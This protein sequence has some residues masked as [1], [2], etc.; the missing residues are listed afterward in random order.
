[1]LF[2]PFVVGAATPNTHE[3]LCRMELEITEG[4][5]DTQGALVFLL[6]RCISNRQKAAEAQRKA[7]V[8]AARSENMYPGDKAQVER[9]IRGSADRISRQAIKRNAAGRK[10]E[11]LRKNFMR[12]RARRTP[13]AGTGS[14][15][16]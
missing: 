14:I 9:R 10:A 11:L 1:M 8:R 13:L 5:E 2:L 4:E 16:Q 12:V 7:D 3:E 6:R 15:T